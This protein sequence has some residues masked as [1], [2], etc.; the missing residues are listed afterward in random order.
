MDFVQLAFYNSYFLTLL[1]SDN[2]QSCYSLS[3][4]SSIRVVSTYLYW[5]KHYDGGGA[6]MISILSSASALPALFTI[7]RFVLN[8]K[9]VPE[10]M[11]QILL[12]NLFGFSLSKNMANFLKA[13]LWGFSS[14]IFL[15]IFRCAWVAAAVHMGNF[16]H[17]LRCA[18]KENKLK[19][20]PNSTYILYLAF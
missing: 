12:K 19:Y 10:K 4:S 20:K 1:S 14:N 5:W 15:E 18:V 7:S 9:H 6:M 11:L 17:L 13:F 3:S 8:K 2:T 16:H